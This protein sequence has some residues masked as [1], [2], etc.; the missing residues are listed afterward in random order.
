MMAQPEE[1]TWQLEIDGASLNEDLVA[2]IFVENR[3]GQLLYCHTDKCWYEFDGF[4]WV[5][6]KIPLSFHY[7]RELVRRAVTRNPQGANKTLTVKFVKAVEVFAQCDPIM[8]RTIEDWNK[9]KFLLGT[10]GGTV[11]LRTGE[12]VE[13]K[14]SDMINRRVA[15][16]PDEFEECPTWHRFLGDAMGGDGTMVRYLQQI[17]GYSLTGDVSEQLLFFGYGDGG[18]GKGVFAGTLLKIFGDYGVNAAMETFEKSS[19]SQHTT[20]LVM[21]NGARFVTA[22]E[23]EEGAAW[24]DKRIKAVTGEDRITARKMRQDNIQFDPTFTIFIIGNHKP[25]VRTVDDAIKRRLIII[26]FTHKPKHKDRHLA[27]KL[28]AEW[29]GILRWAINGCL[30]WQQ[31]GFVVPEAVKKETAEY[32]SEQDVMG[33]WINDCCQVDMDNQFM[34]ASA[35]SLFRSWSAYCKQSGENAG[36]AKTFSQSLKRLHFPAK[37]TSVGIFYSCISLRGTDED[38]DR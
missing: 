32:F 24:N 33:S 11:N 38:R 18:N 17:A 13:S 1:T 7:V 6:Q 14:P 20:D 19:G 30:D 27:A 12:L 9:D 23:T 5:A 16:T 35:L 31:N 21:L 26:P 3:K 10:P 15:V 29:P 4:T 37:R 8:A 25:T 2:R 36:S 34:S 22:S 28:Q